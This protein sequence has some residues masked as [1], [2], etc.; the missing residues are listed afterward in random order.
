MPHQCFRALFVAPSLICVATLASASPPTTTK[1]SK[2]SISKDSHRCNLTIRPGQNIQQAIDRLSQKPGS[3]T[4]CLA[5]GEFDV[6]HLIQINHD[7]FHLRGQGPTTVIKLKEDVQQPLIVVGDYQNQQP[8]HQIRDVVIENMTL[9]GT[10][11][12]EHEFVPDRTYLSNSVIVVRSGQG[13]RLTKLIVNQCRSACLLSEYNTRDFT[14]DR[15]D[16]SGATW[17]GVSFNRSA[18]IHLIHNQIHDNA[19]A[20]MT[21]ENLEDS[22]IKE[23]R[24]ENN[25]S[26]G[27][28]LSDARRNHFTNN[29]FIKN[30]VSGVIFA[31][32]IRYRTPEVLC[33]DNSMSQD[34]VFANNEFQQNPHIYT[35]GVDRAANCKSPDFRPNMWQNNQ[36]DTSGQDPDQDQ[37]GRCLQSQ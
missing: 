19:A 9:K 17:D 22:E 8:D 18:Q 31:C 5:S 4:L 11:K 14:I 27:V 3:S 28:Y 35:I 23:N 7:G 29:Q 30:K 2:N 26:Q 6:D 13:I 32:S 12:I 25:G 36:A 15:S 34:N 21:T 24:F 16:I 37:F 33:W 10:T 1:P 20:G